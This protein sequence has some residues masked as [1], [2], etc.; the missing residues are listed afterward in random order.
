[1]KKIFTIVFLAA[2]I[3]SFSQNLTSLQYSIGFGMGDIGDFIGAPSFRGATFDYRKLVQPSVG[4]GVD[5][6]WNVFYTEKSYDTYTVDTWS[7]SG[8][9]WR[10][11]N[12]V[13]MLAAVDYY[14]KPGEGL[15]PFVGLGIGTMYTRRNTDM[16]Q[17]T[18]EEQA[19]HF[20][21]RPEVGI[22]YEAS[23]ELAFSV[24]GKYYHGFAAGDLPTQGYFA[25]NFGFVFKN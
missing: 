6:G 13:P 24:T 16:G 7:Y 25:L 4:I 10:Y 19:W 21:L 12:Q 2:V 23:P 9:Q 11:N 5:I 20:A 14:L 1:M 18:L 15:N 22:L 17:I 3:P 8:K